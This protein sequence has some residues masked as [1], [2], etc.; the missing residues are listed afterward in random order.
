MEQPIIADAIALAVAPIFL[1]AGIG[2]LLNVMTAR[3][4]R[5]VDRAR[6]LEG[7]L[8]SGPAEATRLRCRDE[9][10]ALGQRMTA[11]NLAIYTTTASALLVCFVVALLFVEQLTPIDVRL[12]VAVLFVMTMALLTGGLAFFLR[13]IAIAIRSL[14]VRRDLLG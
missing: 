6:E 14:K 7:I 3:L 10:S 4:G 1:L 5:V 12:V 13:E 8:D 9:L 2:A 11:S